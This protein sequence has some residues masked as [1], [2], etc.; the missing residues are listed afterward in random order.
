MCRWTTTKITLNKTL[1]NKKLSFKN[2]T[3]PI[4][5]RKS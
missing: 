4:K 2:Q 1:K 5:N 3:K